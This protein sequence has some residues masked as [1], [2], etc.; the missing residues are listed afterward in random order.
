MHETGCAPMV[1]KRLFGRGAMA[2]ALGKAL[3][4]SQFHGA[5]KAGYDPWSCRFSIDGVE[6]TVKAAEFERI[7][8]PAFACRSRADNRTGISG[9]KKVMTDRNAAAPEAMCG[10]L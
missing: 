5:K 4:V 6:K 3:A 8:P 10:R 1:N 2:L 9:Y 7:E